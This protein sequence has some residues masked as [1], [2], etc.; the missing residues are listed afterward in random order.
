VVTLQIALRDAEVA[1]L[2][3]VLVSAAFACAV[4]LRR[5]W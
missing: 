5:L 1:A 3:I 4:I 2:A